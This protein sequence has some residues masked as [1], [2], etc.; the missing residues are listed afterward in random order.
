MGG[1]VIADL[2]AYG[3]R[4]TDYSWPVDFARLFDL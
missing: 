2:A 1:S 4:I 3:A